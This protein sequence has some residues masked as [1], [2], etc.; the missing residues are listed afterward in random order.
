[1]NSTE[2]TA[3]QPNLDLLRADLH[4]LLCVFNASE[5]IHRKIQEEPNYKKKH[6]VFEHLENDAITKLLLST[7]ITL[8]I[9]DD[10][11]GGSLEMFSVYCGLL[12]EESKSLP[13]SKGLTI[14]MACNKIVHASEIE[15][16][17]N[18]VT[19]EV[20]YLFPEIYL[21]GAD[22]H[23]KKWHATINIYEYVRE[24]MFGIGSIK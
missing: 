14:R 24:G 11:E 16:A 23:K 2:V 8:R 15:M 4:Q 17:R 1:M 12:Q 18:S 6:L 5:S 3:Y 10:R 7:A 20:R 21:F 22:Q 19:A 13:E 9:L